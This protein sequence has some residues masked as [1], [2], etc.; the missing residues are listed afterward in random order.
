MAPDIDEKAIR[1]SD[2]AVLTLKL[3][4][5]KAEALLPRI[6]EP[7]ILVT[8]DQVVILKG[9]I[10]EKPVS[11]EQ[12]R[13]FLRSYSDQPIEVVSGVLVTNTATGESA[14]GN[15]IVKIVFNAIP[16]NTIEALIQAGDVMYCG[17]A[18][19]AEDPRLKPFVISQEGTDESLQ[20]VPVELIKSLIAQVTS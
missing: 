18:L 14:E 15:D 13:Q 11:E 3:A 19:K 2:P 20:G 12:A 7:A 8:A 4:H 9:E 17:G 5:A 10:R 1:D 6:T 16:E